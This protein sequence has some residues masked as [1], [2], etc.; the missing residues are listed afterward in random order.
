MKNLILYDR[1]HHMPC[2]KADE[3]QIRMWIELCPNIPVL[4]DT[5]TGAVYQD[6]MQIGNVRVGYRKTW[7]GWLPDTE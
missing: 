3:R 2:S 6:G 4:V 5:D 1:E 7:T